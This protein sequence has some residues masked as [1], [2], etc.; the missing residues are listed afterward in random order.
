MS[1][2]QLVM[3]G[4]LPNCPTVMLNSGDT[5]PALVLGVFAGG[6]GEASVVE[7]YLRCNALQISCKTAKHGRARAA[8]AR[9]RQPP[10]ALADS[11]RAPIRTTVRARAAV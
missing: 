5:M 10:L 7:R 6:G 4:A 11:R 3:P 2:E 9:P 8:P 1:G